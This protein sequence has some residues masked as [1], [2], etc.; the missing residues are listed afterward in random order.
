MNITVLEWILMQALCQLD[1]GS[2]LAYDSEDKC[3][4]SCKEASGSLFLQMRNFRFT[5]RC[6]ISPYRFLPAFRLRLLTISHLMVWSLTQKMIAAV[7]RLPIGSENTKTLHRNV[8]YIFNMSSRC[9]SNTCRRVYTILLY[10]TRTHKTERKEDRFHLPVVKTN[11][12][13]AARDTMQ[14]A[15]VLHKAQSSVTVALTKMTISSSNASW[16][17]RL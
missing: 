4:L 1:I 2:V 9:C 13:Q 6:S 10:F 16:P 12:F 15:S 3:H 11:S 7:F 17:L 5:R 8:A 14:K